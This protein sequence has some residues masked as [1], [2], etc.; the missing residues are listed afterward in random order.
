MHCDNSDN[1]NNSDLIDDNSDSFVSDEY[2]NYYLNEIDEM[3]RIM[4]S[5]SDYLIGGERM[6]E[7]EFEK[8]IFISD[9][10]R[11]SRSKFED[12]D[13]EVELE[14]RLHPFAIE[15]I[16]DDDMNIDFTTNIDHIQPKIHQG[17]DYHQL[18]H[19]C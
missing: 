13:V 14:N 7:D 18:N 10:R 9:I 4:G 19:Y 5:R 2:I 8:E 12:Y 3:D 15:I 16:L 17:I 1:I 6:V 11:M